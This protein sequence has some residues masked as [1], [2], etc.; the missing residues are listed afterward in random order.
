MK[1]TKKKSISKELHIKNVKKA[2][3]PTHTALLNNYNEVSN[4]AIERA[5]LK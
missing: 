2:F 1:Q 5:K 4:E 3:A